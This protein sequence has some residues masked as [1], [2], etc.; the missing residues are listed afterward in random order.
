VVH[1]TAVSLACVAAAPLAWANPAALSGALTKPM[2]V[3]QLPA[4]AASRPPA[5]L[6][7]CANRA[8]NDLQRRAAACT[9]AIATN[10]G[11]INVV[12][13]ASVQRA[14]LYV[15]LKQFERV[16]GDA[17]EIL[18]LAPEGDM[19]STAERASRSPLAVIRQSLPGAQT[20]ATAVAPPV[21]PSPDAA[22]G[23]NTPAPAVAQAPPRGSIPQWQS[24]K[25]RVLEAL[26]AGNYGEGTANLAQEALSMARRTFGDRAPQTLMSLSSLAILYNRQGRLNEAEP[27]FLEALQTARAALGDRHPDTLTTL[28]NL[29]LVYQNQSRYSE[30]EPLYREALQARREALGPR[31]HAAAGDGHGGPGGDG[32]VP[33]ALRRRAGGTLVV[34]S[35]CDTARGDVDYSEGVFGLARALRT[36]GARN[37]LVTLWPLDDLLA[38]DFMA[39]FYKN[40]FS[41]VNGDPAT[42]LRDTQLQWIRDAR[43]SDPAAWAP[44]V[45][46][47]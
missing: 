8:D 38:R 32:G 43:R 33:E 24:L 20:T 19:R 13:R 18:R 2:V 29:A 28:N 15:Q 7:E 6:A 16:V 11:N 4:V 14:S 27:L 40:W 26:K 41:A 31:D 9:R 10:V 21:P 39:D 30:A 3:A 34:L 1:C 12:L 46:I 17:D 23:S 25:A 5:D 36:A 44:Y 47:E 37:V 45:V 42:A 35:A 22:L